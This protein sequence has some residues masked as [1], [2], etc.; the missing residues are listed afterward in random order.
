MNKQKSA[1]DLAFDREREKLR[2]KYNKIIASLEEE[3]NFY[4]ERYLESSA[5]AQALVTEN[6]KLKKLLNLDEEDVKRYIKA[7]E[8]TAALTEVLNFTK[9]YL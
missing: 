6:E 7:S 1:K 4:K 5:Q 3:R 9:G 2:S 8:S